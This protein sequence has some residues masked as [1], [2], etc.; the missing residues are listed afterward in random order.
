MTTVRVLEKLLLANMNQQTTYNPYDV[1]SNVTASRGRGQLFNGAQ[2]SD[3]NKPVIIV[4]GGRAEDFDAVVSAHGGIENVHV[5]VVGSAINRLNKEK[6][7]AGGYPYIETAHSVYINGV[8][9]DQQ[10]QYYQDLAEALQKHPD[11][12]FMWLPPI[13]RKPLMPLRRCLIL[14]CA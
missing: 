12:V 14:W 5:A 3:A 8:D 1:D 4:G 11:V 10:G 6:Q 2:G 9:D 13:A 7:I